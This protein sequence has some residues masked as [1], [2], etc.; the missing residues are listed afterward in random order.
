MED[1]DYESILV[2]FKMFGFSFINFRAMSIRR[3][4]DHVEGSA[5]KLFATLRKHRWWRSAD[6]KSWWLKPLESNKSNLDIS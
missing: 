1:E 3:V 5:Y 4:V 6:L 2:N